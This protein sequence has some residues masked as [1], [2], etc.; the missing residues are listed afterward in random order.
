MTYY[1]FLY[2]CPL[3]FENIKQGG[4]ILIYAEVTLHCQSDTR[5][6][7]INDNQ[8]G[9]FKLGLWHIIPAWCVFSTWVNKEKTY[10]LQV[11]IALAC[12]SLEKNRKT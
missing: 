5:G 12:F 10:D 4:Q 2:A 7:Q 1:V 3:Y 8:A 9:I 11:Y 6:L